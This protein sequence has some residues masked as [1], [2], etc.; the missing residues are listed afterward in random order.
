MSDTDP[1]LAAYFDDARRWREEL[2]ALRAILLDCAVVE[3]R[4]WNQPVYTAHGGNI[5]V[6]HSFKDYCAVGFFKGVLL[7][8]PQ[9]VLVAPGENSRSARV[10][11]FES[12]A[13]IEARDALLRD[14][15][16]EAI[17]NEK[18]GLKVE[19]AKDDLGYPDELV[20]RLDDD[21]AF[22]E[23]FE[24]LTPGRRRG[25]VLHFSQPKQAS[26]RVSRIDKA[27]PKILDGKGLQDR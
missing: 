2:S 3:E 16:A 17:A 26:T 6:L 18:A 27:V 1:R 10:M 22:R 19:F 8:D 15:V 9:S 4:K 7:T 20:A 25:W 14:Y 12:L 13:G 5:A 24:G 11:R 23:A 21:P